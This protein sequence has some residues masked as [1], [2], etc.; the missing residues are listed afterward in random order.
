MANI[1]PWIRRI[2]T[3]PCSHR[4]TYM[5][6]GSGL[7]SINKYKK[8]SFKIKSYLSTIIIFIINSF[9]LPFFTDIGYKLIVR[10]TS[11]RPDRQRFFQMFKIYRYLSLAASSVT[12]TPSDV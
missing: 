4:Y 11:H 7:A 1:R 3:D 12:K 9:I 5:A 2:R 8:S 6:V 10:T